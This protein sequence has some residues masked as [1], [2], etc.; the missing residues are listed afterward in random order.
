MMKEILTVYQK[1]EILTKVTP[2]RP[3]RPSHLM[4]HVLCSNGSWIDETSVVRRPK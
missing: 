3:N 2:K 1:R 4:K